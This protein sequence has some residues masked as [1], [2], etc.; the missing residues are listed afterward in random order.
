MT[1]MRAVQ[2]IRAQFVE[3]PSYFDPHLFNWLEAQ[4]K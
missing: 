4:Q 2:H 1:M 3:T